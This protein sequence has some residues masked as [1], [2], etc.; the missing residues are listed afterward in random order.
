[1][2][3]IIDHVPSCPHQLPELNINIGFDD[4]S[5]S[6]VRR[7]K[8]KNVIYYYEDTHMCRALKFKCVR[9]YISLLPHIVNGAIN[10]VWSTRFL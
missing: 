1:M 5:L 10:G 2:H 9:S 4:E 3:V 6:S 8:S 7:C